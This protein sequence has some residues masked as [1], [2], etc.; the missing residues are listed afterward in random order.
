MLPYN[1]H[2]INERGQR[3]IALCWTMA[4]F[5]LVCNSNQQICFLR[6]SWT[7]TCFQLILGTTTRQMSHKNAMYWSN[8]SFN[9]MTFLSRRTTTLQHVK[10]QLLWLDP[11]QKP[12]CMWNRFYS[13]SVIAFVL[14]S[15]QR[16][17]RRKDEKIKKKK[18]EKYL[19]EK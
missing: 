15:R 10:G 18:K 2:S 6:E 4:S 14:M 5:R 12:S 9:A 1:F 16:G 11:I 17:K 13:M 7:L 3:P 19:I 8:A